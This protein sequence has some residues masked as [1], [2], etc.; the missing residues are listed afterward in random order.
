MA[1]INIEITFNFSKAL[2]QLRSMQGDFFLMIVD[3][4]QDLESELN[5]NRIEI[6]E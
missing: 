3:D 5:I 4:F 2:S 1:Q 6:S